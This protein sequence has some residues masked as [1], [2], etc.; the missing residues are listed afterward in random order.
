MVYRSDESGRF[1]MYVRS[2]PDMG[3]KHRISD[4]ALGVSNSPSDF[5]NSW[6]PDG[7]EIVYPAADTRILVSVPVTTG[8]TFQ[9]EAPRVLM[10]LPFN[11]FWVSMDPS[12]Q[13]FLV[14]GPDMG[15]L[16]PAHSVV[17]NFSHLLGRN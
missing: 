9:F 8:A 3:E 7:R 6:R 10:R 13:K 12:G 11:T 4:D 14:T 17:M 5:W 2:F 1:E 16:P 15:E